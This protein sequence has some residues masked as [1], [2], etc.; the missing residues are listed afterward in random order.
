MEFPNKIFSIFSKAN[1][2]YCFTFFH[3]LV[4]HISCDL[5]VTVADFKI[6]KSVRIM[7]LLNIA[8][9]VTLQFIQ[10]CNLFNRIN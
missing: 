1:H 7:S 6:V 5:F 2:N 9:E 3:R 8:T 10:K 4:F